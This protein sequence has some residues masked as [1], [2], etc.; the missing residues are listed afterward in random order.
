MAGLGTRL[1][2][3][4]WSRPKQLITIAD[5][6]VLGH[7][8]NTFGTLPDPENVEFVFIIGYLG[9]KVKEYMAEKHP[10]LE[11]HYIIQEEMRG[12]SHAIYLARQHL[13]GPMLMVFA[14]TLIESNLSFL[15]TEKSDIVA[16]VQPV[17]DPR[18]FGVAE[19][20]Q[21]GSVNRLIEKPKSMENN[22]A[23]VGFYYFKQS[24]LLVKAIEEQ[25]QRDIQLKS[26]FFLAD[27]IN[28]MLEDEKTKMR[29]EKVD[30][31][32][33]AGTPEAILETNRYLLDHGHDNSASVADSQRV[34]ITPP[35]YIH[36]EAEVEDSVLGPHVSIGARCRISGSI[37]QNTIIEEDSLVGDVILRDALIGQNSQLKGQSVTVNLGDNTKV[38]I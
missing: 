10:E 4:T 37:I 35:V 3:Q 31:W 26:E 20:N 23:V 28:I 11:V 34:C 1:R 33:D 12:Q 6:S 22:L 15:A 17:P 8:L 5:N 18:R 14:D 2:P 13:T 7:V 9:D 19:I 25:I 16:W 32:L 30:V 29:T 24:E 36:P 27:A 21:N 38:E